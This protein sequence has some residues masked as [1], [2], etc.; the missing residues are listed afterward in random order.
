MQTLYKRKSI[1]E[2]Q[3][4]L[5]QRDEELAFANECLE[6]FSFGIS[7]EMHAPVSTL[8]KLL[9]LFKIE[10]IEKLDAEGAE[11]LHMIITSAK[12]TRQVTQGL[13]E[14]SRF[15]QFSNNLEPVDTAEVVREVL[16]QM[17]ADTEQKKALITVDEL[18]VV[19]A[20]YDA[21]QHL[22]T[23][24]IKNALQFTSAADGPPEIHI[25]GHSANNSATVVVADQGIGI[26]PDQADSVFTVFKRLH[27]RVEYEGAGIGLS[28]CR[29][30]VN[31]LNGRIWITTD[32]VKGVSFNVRLPQDRDLTA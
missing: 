27:S 6:R 9:D 20:T 18:P 1:E 25:Y 15:R 19:F 24:I 29:Q 17:Q 3:E 21:I 11:F 7:H 30:I 28:T 32:Q 8:N 10:N 26:N 13:Q 14:F 12:C 31:A 5:A 4:I 23:Q 22:F 16:E 2:L